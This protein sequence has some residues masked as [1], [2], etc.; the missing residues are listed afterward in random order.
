MKRYILI[1]IAFLLI[2]NVALSDKFSGWDSFTSTDRVRYIDYFDD[3]LQVVTSGGW[4]KIDPVTQGF[5]KITNKDGLGTNDLHYIIHDNDGVTWIAGKGRLIKCSGN[6]YTPYLFYDNEDNLM[7]LYSIADDGD[8]LWIATSAGLVLFS[9]YADDGQ[10]ED[11]YFRFGGGINDKPM[12]YDI[13]IMGDSIWVG[14]SDGIA[15]ADKTNPDFLKSPDNWSTLIPSDYS[16]VPIDTVTSLSY[17]N[18]NIYFG[19]TH[20]AF[21][22]NR[23]PAISLTDIPTRSIISVK[24]MIVQGDS[25]M[26]YAGGG[27][28]AYS[29][30]AP[31]SWNNT[32]SIPLY[33]FSAGRLV[34]DTHWIGNYLAGVYYG[35]EDN[36][37]NFDDGGLP[38]NQVTTLS[39]D[40]SG[41]IF[42]GF[43][44]IGISRY[45]IE[46]WTDIGFHDIGSGIS[47]VHFDKNGA[48]WVATRGEGV[49]YITAD[50]VIK[51]KESNS[52]LHGVFDDFSSVNATKMASTS[53]YLFILNFAA[54]DGN[55][56]RVVDLDDISRWGSFGFNDGITLETDN[57]YSLSSDSNRFVIGTSDQGVFYY[58]FG[59]DPFNKSDDS[60]VVLNEDNSRLGSDEVKTIKFDSQGELWI[61]TKFGLSLYDRGIDLFDNISLPEGF[62]PEVK[63]LTFDRRRNVWIGA[64]NGLGRYN[65]RVGTFD[66]YTSL[67]SGLAADDITDLLMDN[68]TS[69]LWI[70]TP[71]G[72]SKLESIIGPPTNIAADVIAFPNPFVI[73]GSEDVLSFNYD[74]NATVR[75]YT[76]NGELVKEMDV[77]ILWDGTNEQQQPLA[78]GAYLYLLTAEDGSVGR[79]KILLV[80]E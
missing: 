23:N 17:Y 66:V 1:L 74:G 45:D 53:H 75:I 70:G 38:D 10:I 54:R 7:T 60:V 59:S 76:V 49:S 3:S 5:R 24:H 58:Y 16:A 13:I 25:L 72:I 33:T 31:I 61:G 11:F 78:S 2:T 73:R 62:G 32:P 46:N 67:N 51:F 30:S 20:D 14:T 52:T 50:T 64:Q 79:G 43:G 36:Y 39:V 42:A 80:R 21:K 57:Y 55:S 19:T 41:N 47:A 18:G 34:G 48:L 6:E 37:L 26:I 12:V 15:Y 68:V 77:N 29:D 27:F 40:S 65:F 4:L 9:K 63:N 44:T 22:L 56:V 35:S 28:F 8:M 71:E 69:D